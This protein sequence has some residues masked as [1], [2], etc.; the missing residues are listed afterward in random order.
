MKQTPFIIVAFLILGVGYLVSQMYTSSA[1]LSYNEAT[2]AKK[3]IPPDFAPTTG[4]PIEMA[5]PTRLRVPKLE[6]NAA[7][8]Q[9]GLDEK[10]RM[11]VPK[12]FNNVG[13]YR[14]GYFP[15]ERGSMV[16]AGHVDR[17]NGD[18]AVFAQLSQL[19]P[20]DE[21]TVVDSFEREY[22]YI[23]EKKEL[24][25]YDRLPLLT[26][27]GANDA[28]RLNLITCAGTFDQSAENYSNRLVVYA[29][30]DSDLPKRPL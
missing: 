2:P 23:V 6:V 1:R 12:D 7:V 18:P 30:R 3:I 11:D 19:E 8:E 16:M 14:L 26:V 25:P 24:Y 4:T 5:F 15:G 28:Q 29:V 9:V 27:F 17:E 22:R 10:Q 13:W 20:G 21:I